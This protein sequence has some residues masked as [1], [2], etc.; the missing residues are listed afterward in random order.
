MLTIWA[1]PRHVDYC[2]LHV[3]NVLS[4]MAASRRCLNYKCPN[5]HKGL[6]LPG[7]VCFWGPLNYEY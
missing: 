7:M 3:T 2:M 6:D 5:L 1:W 4:I